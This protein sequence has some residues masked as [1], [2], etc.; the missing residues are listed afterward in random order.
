MSNI[1][2]SAVIEPGAEVGKDVTIEPY[3]IIKSG[4]KLGD[5]VT[6]KSHAYI[7][8]NT[9][10]GSGTTIYPGASIG[11]KTQDLKYSGETT[12][13]YI[14]KDCEIREFATINSSCG[15]NSTVE[16]GDGCMIMAYCHVAHNCQIGDGVIMSNGVQLAGHVALGDHATIGGM[17]AV[18][19]RVRIGRHAMVGG[20]GRVTADVPPYSMGGGSPFRMAGPNRVGLKRYGFSFR[21]QQAILCCY[22]LTYRSGYRLEEALRRI[23]AEVEALPVVQDWIEFCHNSQRSLI[24]LQGVTLGGGEQSK[25]VDLDEVL[26]QRLAEPSS[27]GG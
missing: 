5:G 7:D 24:G 3:A 14:G 12:F 26:D 23:E 20:M 19:Q 17:T 18:H 21:E 27:L 11:T 9:T 15:E 13:V 4:V 16:I 6:V 22:K 1:H 8:G 10:I 2:P 25:R